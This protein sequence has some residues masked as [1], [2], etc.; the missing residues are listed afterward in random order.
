[1]DGDGSEMESDDEGLVIGEPCISVHAFSGNQ[2]YHTMRIKGM[3]VW[4]DL[5]II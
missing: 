5:Y 1:M 3:A 4:E 2:N